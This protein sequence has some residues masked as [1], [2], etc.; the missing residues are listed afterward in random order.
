[1]RSQ[2]NALT[3]PRGL[4]L[5]ALPIRPFVL[6]GAGAKVLVTLAQGPLGIV[7]SPLSGDCT[8]GEKGRTSFWVS[9]LSVCGEYEIE[10]AAAH[11]DPC[12]FVSGLPLSPNCVSGNRCLSPWHAA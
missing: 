3:F 1:M 5:P 11:A 4:R 10:L 7:V 6:R 2:E 9:A 12:V 8:A